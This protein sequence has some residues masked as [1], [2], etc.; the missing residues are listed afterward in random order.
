MKYYRAWLNDRLVNVTDIRLFL[1]ILYRSKLYWQCT[2]QDNPVKD[3]RQCVFKVRFFKVLFVEEPRTL[4]YHYVDKLCKYTLV[5][6]L[7]R[8]K[9][10][11]LGARVESK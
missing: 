4:K 2:S 11:V 3:R 5:A 8:A 10:V 1:S 9:R 7:W 6:C